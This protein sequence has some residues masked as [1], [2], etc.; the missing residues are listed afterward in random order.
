[1]SSIICTLPSYNAC[2]GFSFSSNW[3]GSQ[4]RLVISKC[5]FVRHIT[6]LLE[7]TCIIH[8]HFRIRWRYEH[9]D[10]WYVALPL[11]PADQVWISLHFIYF[12]WPVRIWVN[13]GPPDPFV[14]HKKRFNGEVLRMRPEKP[15]SH[16][17]AGMAG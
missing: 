6:W 3:L 14:C 12:W 16:V 10:I 8:Y 4:R 13:I 2:R 1:M 11:I 7:I 9:T 15:R 17:T 5:L